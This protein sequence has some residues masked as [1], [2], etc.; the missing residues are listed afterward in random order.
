[1]SGEGSG[2]GGPVRPSV[3][4]LVADDDEDDG[5][6]SAT[7]PAADNQQ[8]GPEDGHS[9]MGEGDQEEASSPER[10]EY[11][12]DD[13]E[14][15]EEPLVAQVPPTQ[16][17]IEEA[18]AREAAA[19][20]VARE[21]ARARWAQVADPMATYRRMGGRGFAPQRRE[22][23]DDLARMAHWEPRARLLRTAADPPE[24]FIR[25]RWEAYALEDPLWVT[26]LANLARQVV[27]AMDPP[28]ARAGDLDVELEAMRPWARR[29][30]L[31]PEYLWRVVN[32]MRRRQALAEWLRR[33]PVVHRKDLAEHAGFLLLN[34]WW[35]GEDPLRRLR[36]KL[37]LP[38]LSSLATEA[39][40]QSI[41]SGQVVSGT[42][43]KRGLAESQSTDR[44][45]RIYGSMEQSTS[46]SSTSQATDGVQV[47]GDEPERARQRA[48]TVGSDDNDDDDERE[49][50]R[51]QD[52]RQHLPTPDLASGSGRALATLAVLAALALQRSHQPL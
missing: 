18:Q 43:R 20:L 30:A 33:Y 4:E 42:E 8:A 19:E 24:A 34:G 5:H 35:S 40:A 28:A 37:P 39:A 49:Q 10:E 32:H 13:W 6:S 52:M 9:Q 47:V 51:G 38:P 21:E 26:D 48:R 1:M 36:E 23:L 44:L 11:H 17:E 46:G 12:S 7:A 41:H 14:D 15:R 2:Q 16:M 50:G 3:P 27:G 45:P 25:D 22:T 31:N 29:Q